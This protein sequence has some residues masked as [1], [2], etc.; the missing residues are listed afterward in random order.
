MNDQGKLMS[1]LAFVALVA[2]AVIQLTVFI[3]GL[4]DSTINLEWA[5]FIAN[6]LLTVVVVWVGWQFAKD[7]SK[8]WKI[9]F[10]VVAVLA[11]F[12]S[13]GVSFL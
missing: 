10:A 1:V 13:V 12:G 3:V 9:V 6:I 11:L 7:K 4:F 8:F 2:T 5:T